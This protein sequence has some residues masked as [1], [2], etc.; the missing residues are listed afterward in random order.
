MTGPLQEQWLDTANIPPEQL[1]LMGEYL[2]EQQKSI[3]WWIG[4]LARFCRRKMGEDN[5]SQAFPANASPGLIQRCEA[6]S[7][8][9]PTKETRNPLATWTQHMTVANKP[10][11]V[12]LVAEMVNRG[13]TSDQSRKN[14]QNESERRWLIAFD[15]HYFAHRH[16]YSG[17]GVETAIQ[18]AQWIQR[19]VERLREKGATDCVCAFEGQGSFRKELTSGDSWDGERY[20]DRPGKPDELRHQLTLVRKLLEGFGFCCVSVDGYEAD[21]VLA[22]YAHQFNGKTTIVS[23]DKDLR[24]CLSEKC[25]MLLDVEWV[26]DETSGDHIPEYKWLSAK[27]HTESTGIPPSRWVEYQTL[28]GDACDGIKGAVGIG[29]KGAADLIKEFGTASAA[30]QAAKDGDE[31]IKPKK[32]EALIAFES[33]L[34]ITRQLVTM[35]TDLTLPNSTRI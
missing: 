30:I 23:S 32:R 3:N 16:Y 10:N 12:K 4:D 35:R 18:V 21:D 1:E 14:K 29:E 27:Q 20:K 13:E 24:S 15:T 25:N 22:S 34:E 7:N 33:K 26:Q 5:Y 8:A 11:R 17:A 2:I 28:M 31:R 9:Y 19:T 6:V